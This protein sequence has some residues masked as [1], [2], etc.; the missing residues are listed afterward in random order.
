VPDQMIEIKTVCIYP[1]DGIKTPGT[2]KPQKTDSYT[3]EVPTD[4][5][6]WQGFGFEH[7]WELMPGDWIFQE[8]YGTK[9][10]AEVKFTVVK[11]DM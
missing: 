11:P 3:R 5:I 8:W 4:R 7:E 6:A 1:G 2:D 10:L 9:K